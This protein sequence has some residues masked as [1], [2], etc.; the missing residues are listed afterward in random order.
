MGILVVDSSICGLGGCPY[1]EGSSGNMATEDVIYMLN[2]VGIETVSN[3][4]LLV[5]FP[6]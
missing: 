3:G 4:V 1:A 6:Y 5:S 2:G